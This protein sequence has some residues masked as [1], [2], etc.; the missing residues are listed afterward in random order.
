M[1]TYDQKTVMQA[2]EKLRPELVEL[3]R[4]LI[5]EKSVNPPG[6][7]TG[8]A[9]VLEAELT[10]FGMKVNEHISAPRRVNVEATLAGAAHRSR[11]LFNG[12]MDVVPEGDPSKWTVDPFGGE[13]RDDRIF[14]RGSTDMKGGL[15]DAGIDLNGDVLFHA[16][17]DEEVDS[18]HGTKYMISKGL[19]RADMGIVAEP[20]VFGKSIVIRQA[21]RG[22]CWIRLRTVGKAAHASNPA[23]GVNAVLKMSRLLLALDR[24]QLKHQPHKILPPPTISAGTVISGGTKT[25]VIPESCQAEVDVRITPGITKDQV[26]KEFANVFDQVRREDPNFSATAEVFAYAPPAEIPEDHRVLDAAK[27]ATEV[28]IGQEPK[29]SAGYGTNDGVY[30]IHDGGVPMIPGFGPGDHES[31]HAHGADENVRISELMNFAKIYA[32]TVMIALGVH[33]K[34]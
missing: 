11:F 22:N 1:P 19:A 17:A 2:I 6:D 8:T 4:R 26:L 21:V 34:A 33:E 7:E 20:S 10:S 5:R 18:V 32:L 24:L 23:G 9:R 31:G 28:V 30:L 15:V 29:L 3:T 12:H 13:V 16:V 14:G 27:K 25:N